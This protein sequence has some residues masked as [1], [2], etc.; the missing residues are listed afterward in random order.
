VPVREITL[1]LDENT[2]LE[3]VIPGRTTPSPD[4]RNWAT[5][6]YAVSSLIR[7]LDIDPCRVMNTTTRPLTGTTMNTLLFASMVTVD[8]TKNYILVNIIDSIILH[9]VNVTSRRINFA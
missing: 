1:L 3:Q 9:I 4:E 2:I 5:F 6:G 7:E 8:V